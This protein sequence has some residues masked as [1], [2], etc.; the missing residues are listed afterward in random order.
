MCSRLATVAGTDQ[1]LHA[2]MIWPRTGLPMPSLCESW[3]SSMSQCSTWGFTGSQPSMLPALNPQ[4]MFPWS[5]GQ[6][7]Q[8]ASS[9]HGLLPCN[10]WQMW[11][12]VSGG[13]AAVQ[14]LGCHTSMTSWRAWCH[15]GSEDVA[16]GGAQ[17]CVWVC[18]MLSKCLW[19]VGT[20][21]H[22]LAH[23][24]GAMGRG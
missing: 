24:E 16:D 22:A 3:G 13:G 20:V 19:R 15:W 21:H 17:L 10:H 2:G 14:C 7:L 1:R 4:K 9:P 18:A 23:L 5:V 12:R 6:E 8:A 11:P